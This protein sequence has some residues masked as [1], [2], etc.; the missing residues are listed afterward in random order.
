MA[1]GAPKPGSTLPPQGGKGGVQPQVPPQGGKGGVQQPQNTLQPGSRIFG[2]TVTPN[3]IGPNGLPIGGTMPAG[4]NGPMPPQG[5]KGAVQPPIQPPI[6]PPVQPTAPARDGVLDRMFPN[7]TPP[8]P[9]MPPQ[10]G[11]GAGQPGQVPGGKGAGQPGQV[12]AQGGKTPLTPQQQADLAP[13]IN[14]AVNNAQQPQVPA[15]GGK[16]PLDTSRQ[17]YDQMMAV[18]SYGPGGPPSYEQFVQQRTA[19]RP[20]VLP[21]K[22]GVPMQ[23]FDPRQAQVYAPYINKT[24]GNVAQRP[25]VL[26]MKPIPGR[27]GPFPA[28]NRINPDGSISPAPQQVGLGQAMQGVGAPQGLAQLQQILTGRQ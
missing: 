10:G 7:Y 21:Q 8:R 14:T 3:T 28:Q 23:P 1:M 24:V 4:Y 17:A 25:Q 9:P 13:Y 22:P 18:T 11:K 6:Q 27:P 19:P 16:A 2:G 26:P 12:P 15:Q 20:Q 5:G